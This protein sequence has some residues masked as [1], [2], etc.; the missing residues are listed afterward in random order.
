MFRIS[1]ALSI[2]NKVG[3]QKSE[4]VRMGAESEGLLSL[5]SSLCTMLLFVTVERRLWAQSQQQARIYDFKLVQ[6]VS[7]VVKTQ[8]TSLSSIYASYRRSSGTSGG[9][10]RH[11]VVRSGIYGSR[12]RARS[13][14]RTL[15]AAAAQHQNMRW[16]G[17]IGVQP[18]LPWRP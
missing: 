14:K 3:S 17:G 11:V 18:W 1:A 16:S 2:S 15:K 12:T 4:T 13:S 9:R 5:P 6:N 8:S 7:R 10:R